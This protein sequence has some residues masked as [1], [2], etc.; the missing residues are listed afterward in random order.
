ME[1]N[2]NKKFSNDK[3]KFKGNGRNNRNDR[4]RNNTP[5]GD[6]VSSLE[7]AKAGDFFEGI[8]KIVRKSVPGPVV[9]SVSDGFKQVDAVTMESKFNVDDVVKLRGPVN[10][11]ANKLQIEIKSMDKS[12]INFDEI[13]DDQSRP[14]ERFLSIQ[15]ERLEKMRPR[16][17]E[18]AQK[19]RRA[20]LDGQAVMI[21]HHNDTDGIS[22]GIALE[23]SIK[24]LMEKAG[25]NPHYY[26]YRS[27]SKAPFYEITDMLFDVVQAK[28]IVTLGINCIIGGLSSLDVVADE[29]LLNEMNNKEMDNDL[30]NKFTNVLTNYGA[31]NMELAVKFRYDTR[32]I[33]TEFINNRGYMS[34]FLYSG[35]IGEKRHNYYLL[36]KIFRWIP[37]PLLRAKV[38]RAFGAV[39]GINT[40]I[41]EIFMFNLANGFRNFS[42]GDNVYVGP[43]CTFDLTQRLVIGSRT[44]VSPNCMFLTHADPGSSYG[45]NLSRL[46]PRKE[47]DVIVGSDCWIGAGVIMLCGLTVGDR[48]AIGAGAVVTKDIPSNSVALG[49]PAVVVKSI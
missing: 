18:I 40:R 37:Q 28:R 31:D 24:I 1:N 23:H 15:S 41:N 32:K 30:K 5:R 19:I 25:I 34:G 35:K 16:M 11:R 49:N 45:S 12:D 9:F 2:K 26:L 47:G 36:E 8:V 3:G 43:H 39:I 6:K 38:L 10:D 14:I 33:F 13:L 4:S 29:F 21:R 46:Y 27:P 22:A 7:V 44:V 20:V 42:L 17:I 48:V